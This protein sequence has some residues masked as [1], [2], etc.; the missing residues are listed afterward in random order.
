MATHASVTRP[1]S[2][3]SV[4]LRV[5]P[6]ES[7]EFPIIPIIQLSFDPPKRPAE[8]TE[9]DISDSRLCLAD[10]YPTQPTSTVHA[11]HKESLASLIGGMKSEAPRNRIRARAKVK[12]GCRTC[13]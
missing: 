9:E 3:A 6:N 5:L 11:Q 8:R 7:A 4:A 13:K 10:L 12:S 2:P 1:F